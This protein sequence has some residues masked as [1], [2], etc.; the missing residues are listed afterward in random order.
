[1]QSTANQDCVDPDSGE[2]DFRWIDYRD[3]FLGPKGEN[4][5]YIKKLISK[6][7]K[8][9]KTQR[10]KIQEK[11]WENLEIDYEYAGVA[12]PHVKRIVWE[13]LDKLNKYLADGTPTFSPHYM[14]HM[15]SDP[16]FLSIVGKFAG[17]LWYQNNIDCEVSE[18]T[19]RIEREVIQMIQK[20]V[21]YI[22]FEVDSNR[23]GYSSWGRLSSCGTNAN[24]DALCMARNKA[25]LVEPLHRLLR[26]ADVDLGN[27]CNVAGIAKGYM[28]HNVLPKKPSALLK[29]TAKDGKIHSLYWE[30]IEKLRKSWEETSTNELE[31]RI[32]EEFG[33][34][35]LESFENLLRSGTFK[36]AKK[37]YKTSFLAENDIG[38]I[39]LL[40]ARKDVVNKRPVIISTKEAHYS[41]K[42]CASGLGLGFCENY[43]IGT[44]DHGRMDM[45][46]LRETILNVIKDP[47]EIL[48]A[49]VV[50]MGTTELGAMDP[51]HRLLELRDEILE[52][53]GEWFLIHADAAW[54]APLRMLRNYPY[55]SELKDKDMMALE[56]LDK[57]TKQAFEKLCDADSITFDPHKLLCVVYPAGSVLYKDG[58]DRDFVGVE[59]AYLWSEEE[60]LSLGKNSLEGSKPCSSATAV[61]LTLKVLE[62]EGKYPGYE[63]LYYQQLFNTRY[64]YAKLRNLDH[65]E[66]FRG[67]PQTNLLCFRLLDS[68][69]DDPLYQ[70]K[71]TEKLYALLVKD[72]GKFLIS[73]ST[74][75]AE[76]GICVL[77]VV[78]INPFLTKEYLDKFVEEI[79]NKVSEIMCEGL[80]EEER[81]SLLLEKIIKKFPEWDEG[82][83]LFMST[84]SEEVVAH[85]N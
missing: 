69:S 47:D 56:K 19:T 41:I 39:G 44:D 58:R 20:M 32:R 34:I 85:G 82:K 63:K 12:D 62:E 4:L 46:E 18:K 61:W 7:I 17:D 8:E 65:V 73:K 53:E 24:F 14:A 36:I 40:A 79:E 72:T 54:G 28:E 49:V 50:T 37:T 81:E 83:N 71:L 16:I 51:L 22:P 68:T 55:P 66:V 23:D 74:D 75:I 52:K 5:H 29:T 2:E 1:M 38:H 64:L 27:E 15:L 57:E 10:E 67:P 45:E 30:A 25:L 77:R 3:F 60:N 59:A 80:S 33:D 76:T 70:N 9:H 31:N 78:P 21:G 26:L 42:K 35:D 6:V 13:C 48:V 11:S 84:L 43:M